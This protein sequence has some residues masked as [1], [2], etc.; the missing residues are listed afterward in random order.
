[1]LSPVL[2][3]LK[4]LKAAIDDIDVGLDMV[5]TICWKPKWY[6][7]QVWKHQLLCSWVFLFQFAI[8]TYKWQ[9]QIKSLENFD[10]VYYY[11]IETK[12]TVKPQLE[13]TWACPSILSASGQCWIENLWKLYQFGIQLK[14]QTHFLS[15][16]WQCWYD[17]LSNLIHFT[18]GIANVSSVYLQLKFMTEKSVQTFGRKV[19]FIDI[20][21]M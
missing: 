5:I 3:V 13:M 6:S 15:I 7:S 8:A 21:L 19:I 2:K 12:I 11:K 18:Q 4:V 9:N 1:M 20:L 10:C 17:F 14:D 16:C